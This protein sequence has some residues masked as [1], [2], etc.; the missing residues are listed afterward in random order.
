MGEGAPRL[1]LEDK[2]KDTDKERTVQSAKT[3]YKIKC[4]F[5]SQNPLKFKVVLEWLKKVLH[6]QCD[7]YLCRPEETASAWQRR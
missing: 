7:V 3:Q 6:T 5:Q 4:T 1:H 2:D